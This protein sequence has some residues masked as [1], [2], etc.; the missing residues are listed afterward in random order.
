MLVAMKVRLEINP[1]MSLGRPLHSFN[2]FT[3]NLS[4]PTDDSLLFS[5]DPG[6]MRELNRG[7]TKFKELVESSRETNSSAHPHVL[8]GASVL[9]EELI[10]ALGVL[11]SVL[12]E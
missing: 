11:L 1:I 8:I 9:L 4:N 3:Q 6:F 7:N 2:S 12:L 5:H 10:L